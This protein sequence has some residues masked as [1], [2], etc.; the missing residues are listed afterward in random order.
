MLPVQEV[1]GEIP[2]EN[3]SVT[4]SVEM[5]E[6]TPDEDIFL[7]GDFN[8]WNESDEDFVLEQVE[9]HLYEITLEGQAHQR[10]L[11]YGRKN[12]VQALE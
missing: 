4:F 6:E 12:K 9:G 1:E 11:G 10:F 8:E 7:V 2:D 3:Y 5:P